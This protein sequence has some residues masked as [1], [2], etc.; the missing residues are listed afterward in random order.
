MFWNWGKS[1][2]NY[3]KVENVEKLVALINAFL[4]VQ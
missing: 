1:N 4:T 2:H 3:S